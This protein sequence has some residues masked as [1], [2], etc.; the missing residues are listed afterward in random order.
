MWIQVL[1]TVVG[2]GFVVVGAAIYL[3]ST[4]QRT[5]NEELMA[6]ADTRGERIDDLEKE[7]HEMREEMSEMRGKMKLLESLKAEE[8]AQR[9]VEL[10]KT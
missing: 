7:L 1:F 3:K 6:L 8:I 10:I 4:I 5:N 2:F 9:V